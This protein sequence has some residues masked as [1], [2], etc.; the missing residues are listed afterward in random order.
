MRKAFANKKLRA[1]LLLIGLLVLAAGLLYLFFGP[2][3]DSGAWAVVR[4]DGEEEA[5][6]SLREN[7]IYPLNGGTNT[8]VI[9]DG[10]AWLCDADC[11][12]KLCVRQGKIKYSGQCI[13]CLPNRL[14]VTL[15]GAETCIEL[16]S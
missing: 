13:T 3:G 8:L 5:R 2:G 15:E 7:G 14:T 6:Y 1:D 4:V 16:V 10:A 11:P 12:D 9:E